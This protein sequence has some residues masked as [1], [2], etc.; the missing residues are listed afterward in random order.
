MST[1]SLNQ[2]SPNIKKKKGSKDTKN[3]KFTPT[4][5]LLSC[6]KRMDTLELLTS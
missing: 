6:A 2:N 1:V 3:L 5:K 4:L